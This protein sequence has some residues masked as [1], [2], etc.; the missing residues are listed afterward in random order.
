MPSAKEIQ[1]E[2]GKALAECLNLSH[3]SVG[4]EL[5]AHAINRLADLD[6]RVTAFWN[7]ARTRKKECA[8]NLAFGLLRFIGGSASFL[9]MWVKI[10]QD[11]MSHAWDCLV[12]AQDEIECGLRIIDSKELREIVQILHVLEQLLFPPQQFVSSSIVYEYASC[13]ICGGVYGECGHIAGKL[14]M[15]VMCA[16]K[17]EN[18][19][20]LDHLAYVK[21]PADK[22]CRV[23]EIQQGDRM[24]CTL[25]RRVLGEV[26]VSGT[27]LKMTATGLRPSP[28]G[29]VARMELVP[30]K[31]NQAANG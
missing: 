27:G 21:E 15:G 20:H 14:Y 2:V 6:E 25:T 8:A 9:R 1:A 10:K 11:E 18:V 17:V 31:E 5:Q 3:A 19:S 13:T 29:G 26:E 30:K 7:D 22:A 4:T 16:K 12:D 23:T 24:V 28:T